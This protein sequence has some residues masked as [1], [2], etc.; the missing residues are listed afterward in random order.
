M[1]GPAPN[2]VS[3][4]FSSGVGVEV[5]LNGGALAATVLLP[6]EFSNHSQGLLALKAADQSRGPPQFGRGAYMEDM[7]VIGASCEEVFPF[8]LIQ[9]LIS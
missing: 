4:M 3:V 2:H 8:I 7:F 9:I 1:F 5:H 6:A